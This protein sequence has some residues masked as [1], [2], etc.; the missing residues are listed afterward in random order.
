MFRVVSEGGLVGKACDI[1]IGGT[2]DIHLLISVLYLPIAQ[3]IYLL[4]LFTCLEKATNN[5]NA[6]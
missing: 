3:S 1:Y 5:I 4:S 2:W 6:E